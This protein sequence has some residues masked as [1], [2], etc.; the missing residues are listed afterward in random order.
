[1]IPSMSSAFTSKLCF[2][3]SDST[4][5]VI[6]PCGAP[7]KCVPQNSHPSFLRRV[8][9]SPLARFALQ[10]LVPGIE[11]FTRFRL[12]KSSRVNASLSYSY[13]NYTSSPA[14]PLSTKSSPFIL[15]RRSSLNLT[16]YISSFLFNRLSMLV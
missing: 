9:C 11:F 5:F 7:L 10:R 16:T 2:T 12:L 6:N 3:D 4:L 13:I 1:M 8:H 15:S 14:L